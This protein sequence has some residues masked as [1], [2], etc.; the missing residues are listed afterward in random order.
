M[1]GVAAA[2]SIM[3]GM[4]PEKLPAAM[5]EIMGTQTSECPLAPLAGRGLG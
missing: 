2:M 5:I 1:G 3:H 4:M